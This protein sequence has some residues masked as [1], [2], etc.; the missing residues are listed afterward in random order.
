MPARRCGR[1]GRATQLALFAKAR[2]ALFGE[3]PDK[4]CP[5][6]VCHVGCLKCKLALN[7][8]KTF[9]PLAG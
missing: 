5:I 4:N 2:V 3:L 6:L 9:E 7:E 8:K 1:A